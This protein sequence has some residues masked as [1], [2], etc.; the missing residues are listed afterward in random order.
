[1][2]LPS[3]L[4]EDERQSLSDSIPL[5]T[6]AYSIQKNACTE[7]M[8]LMLFTYSLYLCITDKRM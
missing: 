3:D 2:Q 4:M 6:Y 7:Q 1:M 8:D 5:A